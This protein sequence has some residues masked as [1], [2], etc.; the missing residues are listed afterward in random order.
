MSNF[1]NDI[2]MERPGPG[3]RALLFVPHPEAEEAVASALRNGSGMVGFGNHD[4]SVTVYFENNKFNDSALHSWQNKVFKAYG[5][6]VT[7][8]PTVNKL[9]CDV[10]NL[11]PVGMIEGSEILVRE[12]ETLRAWLARSDALDSM[13][14]E[15]HIH[16]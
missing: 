15:A 13:P 4:G 8:S 16:T 5:R 14:A 10:P 2:P 12:M 1:G 7:G 9:T 6:M 3:G 11:V